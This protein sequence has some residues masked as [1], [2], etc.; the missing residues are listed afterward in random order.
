MARPRE[1]DEDR[2]VELARDA[3]WA[4]G[5]TATSISDLSSATGLS[6][7]SLYKAFDNKATLC[8]R[9]LDDY[10]DAGLA[11]TIATL[12][13]GPT[14]LDGIE[15]FLDFAATRASD[16]SPTRGCY[17]V[18][19]TVE[20][21]ATD[22]TVRNRIRAHDRALRSALRQAIA[23]AVEDGQM[24]CDPDLGARLLT[25]CVNGVQ[26]EARKGIDEQTA[27]DTLHLALAALTTER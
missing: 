25:T 10:L 6:V 21:A 15:A 5:V 4:S 1:F 18:D 20:L 24:N 9:T 2:V 27:L 23:R 26:V 8:H 11:A 12:E 19:I 17:A 3:F 13:G 7:G 22:E 16:P 14:P